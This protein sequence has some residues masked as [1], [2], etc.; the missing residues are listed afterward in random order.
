M[1]VWCPRK[2]KHRLMEMR[3]TI[4]ELKMEFNEEVETLRG[5]QVEM[6]LELKI[7]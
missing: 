7:Q 6:N 4:Q 3:K 2:H 1:P 5:A